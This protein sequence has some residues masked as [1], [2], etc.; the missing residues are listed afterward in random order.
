MKNLDVLSDASIFV[1][2]ISKHIKTCADTVAEIAKKVS[3][4]E[5]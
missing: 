2:A 3:L 1:V 4:R 5:A